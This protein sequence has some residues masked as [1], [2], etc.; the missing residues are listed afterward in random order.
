MTRRRRGER[1]GSTLMEFVLVGIPIIFVLIS[2]FEIARGMWAY[3][4]LAYSVKR[5][6]RYA[7]VHGWNCGQSG[8]TCNVTV[9]QIA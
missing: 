4:T 1:G 6:L 7:I 2:T 3:Q 9:G 8:N 5:G